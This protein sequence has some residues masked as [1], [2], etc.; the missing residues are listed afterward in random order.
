MN[1][2]VGSRLQIVRMLN[3]WSQRELAKRA[4]VTNSTISMIE[5]GRVSPSVSSL[6]RLLDGVPMSLADF[7][8]M[9]LNADTDVFYRREDMVESKLA[10]GGISW[11][12]L[13]SSQSS[14]T[15]SIKHVVY[16]PGSDTGP[17]QVSE[18]E[19]GGIVVQG[20]IEAYVAG[21]V[22]TLEP[23]EG[24]YFERYLPHRFRNRGSV[25]CV[26]VTSIHN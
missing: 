14:R 15:M 5:Q 26:V 16:S 22:R 12:M 2:E 18:S 1:T 3:G 24:Y 9:K 25:D 11:R 17:M 13:S 10:D 20:R 7:F 21:Q 23:G 8:N 19:E 4:G 6:Q